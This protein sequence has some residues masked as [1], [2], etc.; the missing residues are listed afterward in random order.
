M[1]DFGDAPGVDGGVANVG[2]AFGEIGADEIEMAR[3][4][5]L[6]NERGTVAADGGPKDFSVDVHLA[7]EVVGLIEVAGER[8]GGWDDGELVFCYVTILPGF[9]EGPGGVVQK[10]TGEGE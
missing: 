10:E 1:E 6:E 2:L 4:P 7:H 5:D 3:G 9:T 8:R